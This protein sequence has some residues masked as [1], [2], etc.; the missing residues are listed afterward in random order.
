MIARRYVRCSSDTGTYAPTSL[1]SFRQQITHV[2]ADRDAHIAAAQRS[3]IT[4]VDPARLRRAE[5]RN[6]E[7]RVRDIWDGLAKVRKS[8]ERGQTSLFEASIWLNLVVVRDRIQRLREN[9]AARRRTLAAATSLTSYPSS[10]PS[11]HSTSH[12]PLPLTPS[13]AV[14]GQLP[15]PAQQP[16]ASVS[17]PHGQPTPARSSSILSRSSQPF[18]SSL[19]QGLRAVT[20]RGVITPISASP[21]S[22]SPF[23][24]VSP[25]TLRSGSVVSSTDDNFDRHIEEASFKSTRLSDTV[26]RARS[27]LVQELVEVF[28]VVEVRAI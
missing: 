13:G 7:D 14:G 1:T 15:V 8:N 12:T 25:P 2:A 18:P 19:P 26:A 17:P 6:R 3:L 23:N 27:G 10:S 16:V 22:F 21:P 5:V 11:P 20:A 4:T 28:S 24:R 9:L